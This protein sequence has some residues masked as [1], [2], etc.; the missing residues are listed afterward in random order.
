MKI[1]VNVVP[2]L[3][4]VRVGVRLQ[5]APLEVFPAD[6]TGVDVE[7]RE[8]N[9]TQLLKVKIEEMAIDRVEIRTVARPD[10]DDL[11]CLGEERMIVTI[12]GTRFLKGCVGRF[13]GPSVT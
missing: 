1:D 6:E 2:Q 12:L 11:V 7:M 3:Y 9:R 13:V 5:P 8:R 4:A 10:V